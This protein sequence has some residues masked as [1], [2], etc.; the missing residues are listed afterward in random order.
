MGHR[1]DCCLVC[2][3]ESEFWINILKHGGMGAE[4]RALGPCT[5]W[6][7]PCTSWSGPCT[8][9]SGPDNIQG[10]TSC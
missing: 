9:W 1:T 2:Q 3:V 6:L 4:G 7:G 10:A 8:S 5:S